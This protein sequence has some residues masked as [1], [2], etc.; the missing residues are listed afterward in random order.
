MCVII[1]ENLNHSH[2]RTGLVVHLGLATEGKDLLLLVHSIHHVR[3]GHGVHPSI[4]IDGHQETD[5]VGLQVQIHHGTLHGRVQ[6]GQ[7]TAVVD[8]VVVPHGDELRITLTTVTR[9]GG[10]RSFGRKTALHHNDVLQELV[11]LLEDAVIHSGAVLGM[12]NSDTIVLE[13]VIFELVDVKSQNV[14]QVLWGR[15]VL[16][17][18]SHEA[19]GHHEQHLVLVGVGG[20]QYGL[21]RFTQLVVSLVITR[22][23]DHHG[24]PHV[25]L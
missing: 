16:A 19:I 5:H 24:T 17:V 18:T 9:L 12:S 13:R 2:P 14:G 8:A 25:L 22:D 10:R 6:L 11:A 23:H 1:L 3:D 7:L 15:Q 21:D 4:G 20:V